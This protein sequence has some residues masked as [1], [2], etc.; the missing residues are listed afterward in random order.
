ME[1]DRTFHRST[2]LDPRSAALV[3]IFLPPTLSSSLN[4]EVTYK[5]NG[6][7]MALS[8][9]SILV[10]V[11]M[12]MQSMIPSSPS[13]TLPT[14]SGSSSDL[15]PKKMTIPCGALKDL[16][17][18]FVDS[19]NQQSSS[20]LL[21][22]RVGDGG[23]DRLCRIDDAKKASLLRRI[24]GRGPKVL[25]QSGVSI[26]GK[27][28]LPLT[29]SP[30]HRYEPVEGGLATGGGFGRVTE[31]R[32]KSTGEHV[33]VKTQPY[34][35]GTATNEATMGVF[36]AGREDLVQVHEIYRDA[37][38]LTV[39]MEKLEECADAEAVGNFETRPTKNRKYKA[40]GVVLSDRKPANQR[41]RSIHRMVMDQSGHIRMVPDQQ[42]V[43]I[44][45]GV[46][47]IDPWKV[48]KTATTDRAAG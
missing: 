46:V 39:I 28:I 10:S 7:M 9:L 1:G 18:R 48:M 29:E 24:L 25:T 15:L 33:I 8:R 23:D 13:S 45:Y 5:I 22:G 14:E 2:R 4:E 34:A 6:A 12:M 36:A 27:G 44:D 26:S 21:R 47:D 35:L 20:D 42:K 41:C 3:F 19:A 17:V 16:M 37:N 31:M 38:E 30:L 11:T 43:E 40:Q 32:E